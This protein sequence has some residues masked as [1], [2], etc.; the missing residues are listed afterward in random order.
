MQIICVNKSEIAK[1]SQLNSSA[2]IQP[3]GPKG[4]QNGPDKQHV[5]QKDK[6]ISEKATNYLSE[7]PS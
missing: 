3:I 2:K 7:P 5:A 4:G 1:N 6:L